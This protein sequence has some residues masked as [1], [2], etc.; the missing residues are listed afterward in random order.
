ME[1][2]RVP[3]K[4][5]RRVIAEMITHAFGKDPDECCGVLLGKGENITRSLKVCNVHGNKT[6]RYT[7]DSVQLMEVE[8]NA[9]EKNEQIIAFY[10]SHTYSQGYP[11]ATDVKNAVESG[12][13][14]PYYVLISLV[15]KTRP[16]VRA[17][18]IGGDGSVN[19][20]VITTD[21]SPYIEFE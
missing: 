20:I 15:E 5:P 1:C 16:N 21:G 13:I 11:S 2:D 14:D 4:I 19:E 6:R 17:Y 8:R 9:D 10:H 7:M 3:I 18:R 12:W